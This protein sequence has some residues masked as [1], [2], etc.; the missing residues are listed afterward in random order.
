M[1]QSRLVQPQPSSRTPQ[2]RCFLVQEPACLVTVHVPKWCTNCPGR[3]VKFWHGFLHKPSENSDR[4]VIAQLDRDYLGPEYF[5]VNKCFGVAL[6]WLRRWR[7]RLYFHRASFQGEALLL[8]QLTG[9]L[10]MPGDILRPT[11]SP[12]KPLFHSHS[13]FCCLL[14]RPIASL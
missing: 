8:R 3:A 6:S 14:P 11:C 1:C 13:R 12:R 4:Q 5:L 2:V 7:Y 10:A 9:S